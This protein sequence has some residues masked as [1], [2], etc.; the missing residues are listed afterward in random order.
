[1]GVSKRCFNDIDN[2]RLA[3]MFE[4][5]CHYD[6]ELI[7]IPGRANITADD[8]SRLDHTPKEMP[9]IRSHIPARSIR[10]EQTR[11]ATTKVGKDLEEIAIRGQN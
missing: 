1:M 10:T 8:L 9:E 2:P 11:Q 5:I 4:L 3:K 7:H 6:F